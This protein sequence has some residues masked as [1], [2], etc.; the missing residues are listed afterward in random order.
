MKAIVLIEKK[1]QEYLDELTAIGMERLVFIDESGAHLGYSRDYAR[2]IG[3]GR[4]EDA[5]P[6]KRHSLYT[7]I[8]AISVHRVHAALYGE[9]SANGEIFTTFLRDELLPTLTDQHVVIM[10]NV[11]FHKVSS[12]LPLIE[13]TG[14]RLV[15]LP[16]Y[17][18]DL[19]PIEPMWSKIKSTLKKLRPR[20]K[21]EFKRAIKIA[22]EAITTSDLMGWFKHCGYNSSIV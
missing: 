11:S 2:I 1:R 5:K 18:P 3:G 22:F 13:E 20:T 16:P 21:A 4:I 10:D 15:Y 8:G 7:M 9:W 19:N 14:A 6:C 12:I 17:S